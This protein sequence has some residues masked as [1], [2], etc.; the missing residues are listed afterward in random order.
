MATTAGTPVDEAVNMILDI[1]IGC[2]KRSAIIDT[3][4]RIKSVGGLYSDNVRWRVTHDEAIA[5]VKEGRWKFWAY[6]GGKK[7]RIV[8]ATASDGREYLKTESDGIIP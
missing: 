7:V 2:V 4:E 8:V 6:S 5:G 1:E 3:H